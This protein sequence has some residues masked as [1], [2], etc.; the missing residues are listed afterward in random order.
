MR[1]L[2]TKDE[3]RGIWQGPPRAVNC[4]L[5]H[6]LLLTISTSQV[7]RSSFFH[8]P[9]VDRAQAIPA[10]LV[11]LSTT[12][13]L[14]TGVLTISP[15]ALYTTLLRVVVGDY[16]RL[17]AGRHLAIT[18]PNLSFESRSCGAE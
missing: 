15:L 14:H 17:A 9:T 6:S 4:V 2:V 18:A 3:D 7:S 11:L 12:R 8:L 10:H 13:R 16:S 1:Q 5:E